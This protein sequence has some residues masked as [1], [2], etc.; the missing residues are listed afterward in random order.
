[1]QNVDKAVELIC[2][3]GCKTVNQIRGKLAKGE[4]VDEVSGLSLFERLCVRQELDE[5][6]GVYEAK[7]QA[8][9]AF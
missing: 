7:Q 1:M 9:P 3:Q 6:M 2:E 4:V 5:I 8:A